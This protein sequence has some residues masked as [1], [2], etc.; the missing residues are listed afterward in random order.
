MDGQPYCRIPGDKGGV[1][2]MLT[3]KAARQFVREFK[4]GTHMFLDRKLYALVRSP[5]GQR[6][7]G[8]A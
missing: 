3:E 4:K 7:K 5:E 1:I 6:R 2:P 8:I